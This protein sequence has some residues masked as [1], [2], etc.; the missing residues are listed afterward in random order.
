[1]INIL[2]KELDDEGNWTNR[3]LLVKENVKCRT[4]SRAIDGASTTFQVDSR[5]H[6]VKVGDIIECHGTVTVVDQLTRLI[7][8]RWIEVECSSPS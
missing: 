8:D 4:W 2:A 7:E 5:Y 6:E 1:M 3:Y